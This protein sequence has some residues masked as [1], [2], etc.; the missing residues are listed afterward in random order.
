[1]NFERTNTKISLLEDYYS[2]FKEDNRLKTRHGQVEFLTN[3]KYIESYLQKDDKII[4]IGA[5]T[6][7]YSG[8]LYQQGYDITCV[9]NDHIII[10]MSEGLR[11]GF[12]RADMNSFEI[13]FEETTVTIDNKNY[14][15]FTSRNTYEAGTYNIDING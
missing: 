3:L 9:D 13:P 2:H 15:V 11:P 7:A 5:G 8:Y 10:V 1:M 4:D 6:G 12:I 14:S